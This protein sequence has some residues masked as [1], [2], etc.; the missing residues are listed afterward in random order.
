MTGVQTCALPILEAMQ[1]EIPTIISKQSGC[2]EIL[3]KCVKVD[4]WDVHAMSDYIYSM[5]H[6]PSLYEYFKVEGKK[7]VD[8]IT[9]DKV[10]K[11][12]LARYKK[13]IA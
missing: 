13:L 1:C 8:S 7:E 6:N 12:I 9:W 11:K 3:N 4:Y 2:A 10:G 5:C